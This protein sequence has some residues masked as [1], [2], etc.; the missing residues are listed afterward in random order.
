MSFH[1]ESCVIKIFHPSGRAA[2]TGFVLTPTLAV[3]CAHVVA[4]AGRGPGETLAISFYGEVLKPDGASETR[5]VSEEVEPDRP[6]GTHEVSIL[7]QGWAD[8]EHGDV[9]FLRLD[10]LPEGVTPVELARSA[11]ACEGQ[12]FTSFGFASVVDIPER[13]AHGSLVGIVQAPNGSLL[14]LKAD[15]LAA[16]MSGAPIL[17]LDTGRVVG[18]V[19][20]VPGI[21]QPD[22]GLA[23]AIPVDRL[24]QLWPEGEP[25][26]AQ[27]DLAG[28]LRGAASG[29]LP[30]FEAFLAFYLG[31]PGAPA[32]FGGRQAQLEELDAWLQDGRS[33]Y[34]L[35]AAPA[36]RGKSALLA[37]WAQSL[38]ERRRGRVAL[39]P[40]S[41]RFNIH[42][43]EL[44]YR[45]LAIS[46]AGLY[47]QGLPQVNRPGSAE[48]WQEVCRSLMERTPPPGPPAV[49]ILDGLDELAAEPDSLAA[50]FPRERPAAAG[51]RERQPGLKVLASARQLSGDRDEQGWI[52]RLEW[53][54]RAHSFYL[55]LLTRAG[56]DEVLRAMGDPLARL[57]EQEA[58]TAEFFRL[59]QGDP[60][61]VRLYVEALQAE[62]EGIANLRPEDLPSI[63]RGLD[64]YMERWWKDQ[65]KLWRAEGRDVLAMTQAVQ[66]FLN[67]LALAPAPLASEDVARIAGGKLASRLTLDQIV[68]AVGRL[69]AGDGSREAG[70]A[71]S[72]PRL[73]EYFREKMK[74]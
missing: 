58:L 4:A 48:Q 5:Q 6:M 14:Q 53:Q 70:Y 15:F 52:R 22:P 27:P 68:S 28:Y 69:V 2:G 62:G 9:A 23:Y 57:P 44:V 34:G 73:A 20:K 38:L 72:H 11:T 63:K 54:R 74:T 19:C 61:M 7:D 66:D 49:A 8:P 17:H 67:L 12:P 40:I 59:T 43:P 42:T 33:P 32:P 47:H 35:L 71:I 37:Q 10:G 65:Q 30:G 1:L 26:P 39:I 16:G 13:H 21:F 36:G 18:M 25:R 3:T 29:Y 51:P 55:P 31:T 56:L 60:L 64:G 45:A 24:W 46:L 50:L 41:L